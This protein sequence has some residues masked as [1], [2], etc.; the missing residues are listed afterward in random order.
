ML[1]RSSGSLSSMSGAKFTP[2]PSSLNINDTIVA[3]TTGG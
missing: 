2:V 3:E 1:Q